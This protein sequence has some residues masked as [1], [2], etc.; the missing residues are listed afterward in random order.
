MTIDRAQI[1]SSAPAPQDPTVAAVAA[2]ASSL[3]SEA[4]PSTT[5][6][7]QVE[8]SVGVAPPVPIAR[9][10]ITAQGDEAFAIQGLHD[11]QL[12]RMVIPRTGARLDQ[13]AS[14]TTLRTYLKLLRE[15]IEVQVDPGRATERPFQ[16]LARWI[17]RVVDHSGADVA[18]VIDEQTASGIPWEML[19]VQRTHLGAY[20]TTVRWKY[21]VDDNDETRELDLAPE[22][23][24]G[25]LVTCPKSVPDGA[26]GLGEQLPKLKAHVEA[27]HALAI[28]RCASL[29]AFRG[30]LRTDL[31]HVGL[32]YVCC[33][34]VWGGPGAAFLKPLVG[35]ERVMFTELMEDSEAVDPVV[36]LNACSSAASPSSEDYLQPH[37]LVGFAQ[38]FLQRGAAAVVATISTVLLSHAIDVAHRVIAEARSSS[39]PLAVVLRDLRREAIAELEANRDDP[40]ALARWFYTFHYVLY[41]SPALRL[42]LT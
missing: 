10:L 14:A 21:I 31:R 33:H 4:V 24:R 41:G 5:T 27:L 40:A 42:E 35:D 1:F 36:F 20:V 6:T 16:E 7:R 8:L 11:I 19:V 26:P 25:G 28:D 34:A 32:V 22:P 9:L 13:L 39:K 37:Q 18:L 3:A 12:R 2:P 23:R 15:A 38:P 29:P 30:R 17:K